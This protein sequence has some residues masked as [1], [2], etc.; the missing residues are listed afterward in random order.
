MKF[1]KLGVVLLGLSC[2]ISAS[3][4]CKG[5]MCHRGRCGRAFAARR[6]ARR[7]CAGH[8]RVAARRHHDGRRGHGRSASV[9]AKKM[10]PKACF[11]CRGG[12]CKLK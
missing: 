5:G 6:I 7:A 8:S 4:G 12:S 1:A 2:M 3:A 11:A 9:A 10:A